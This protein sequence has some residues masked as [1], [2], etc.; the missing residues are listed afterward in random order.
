AEAARAW[1]ERLLAGGPCAGMTELS[2]ALVGVAEWL[3]AS[4][5]QDPALASALVVVVTDGEDAGDMEAIGQ[6]WSVLPGLPVAL[7]VVCLGEEN[8]WLKSWVADVRSRGGDGGWLHLDDSELAG[9]P[10]D[11]DFR[12]PTLLPGPECV[13]GVDL[14]RLRPHLEALAKVSSGEEPA[15]PPVDTLRFD[16][17]FPEPDPTAAGVADASAADALAAVVEAPAAA[18]A[19][20]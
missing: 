11:F 17:F 19:R 3:A 6:A 13:V 8:R 20:G 9:V 4:R 18:P 1:L 14:E 15:L 16:A 2:A 7:R 10:G 12:P 5:R